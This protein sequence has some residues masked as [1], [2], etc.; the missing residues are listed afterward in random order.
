MEILRNIVHSCVMRRPQARSIAQE[1]PQ[2]QAVTLSLFGRVQHVAHRR[3]PEV[4][5]PILQFI[6]TVISWPAH[7]SGVPRMT[8]QTGPVP[9][10]I[11]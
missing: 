7:Q 1:I 3:Q 8:G 4:I 9:G 6:R 5:L 11:F 10:A 2:T